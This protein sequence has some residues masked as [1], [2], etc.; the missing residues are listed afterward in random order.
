MKHWEE[1][2]TKSPKTPI[3]YHSGPAP[4]QKKQKNNATPVQPHSKLALLP[5]C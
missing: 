4:N 1:L 5:V 2:A 3:P